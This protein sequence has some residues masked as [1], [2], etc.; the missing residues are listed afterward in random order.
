M[1]VHVRRCERCGEPFTAQRSDKRT[2][3]N[4][5]RK[6]ICVNARKVNALV[7]IDLAERAWDA[8]GGDGLLALESAINVLAILERNEAAVAA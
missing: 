8:A 3:S 4:R 7:P 6:A 1:A 5:C 2:C